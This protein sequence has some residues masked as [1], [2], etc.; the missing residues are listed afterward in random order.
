MTSSPRDLAQ[1]CPQWCNKD[2]DIG[3][4][5][6]VAHRSDPVPVPAVERRTDTS[7]ARIRTATVDLIIGLERLEETWVWIGPGDEGDRALVLS[8][9]STERLVRQLSKL[10]ESHRATA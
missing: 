9:E 6:R 10:L 8:L 5:L 2:H 3:D 7:A 4:D 1:W